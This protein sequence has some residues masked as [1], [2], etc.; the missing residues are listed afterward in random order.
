MPSIVVYTMAAYAPRPI[1]TAKPAATRIQAHPAGRGAADRSS[2]SISASDCVPAPGADTANAGKR[3]VIREH[4]R[5]VTPGAFDQ[6]PSGLARQGWERVEDWRPFGVLELQRVV[7]R[8]AHVDGS[9]L[10][11]GEH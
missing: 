9:L 3:E 7:D 5:P 1:M 4:Q 10:T 8:I 2:A 11:A 6:R